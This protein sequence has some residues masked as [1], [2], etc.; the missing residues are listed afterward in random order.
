MHMYQSFHCLMNTVQI[1]VKLNSL[2]FFHQIANANWQQEK[3][4]INDTTTVNKRIS[5]RKQDEYK[6]DNSEYF[7]L[8]RKVYWEKNKEYFSEKGKLYR[9][10][11]KENEQERHKKYQDKHKET[12]KQYSKL[13]RELNKDLLKA[14]KEK[15]RTE[16]KDFIKQVITCECGFTHTRSNKAR[17]IKTIRHQQ[18]LKWLNQQ[19]PTEEP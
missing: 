10:Q 15:Y 17:H 3:D 13:Y 14:K 7:T 19:E 8:Q 9:E 2:S 4:I 1:T 18:Y 16:N 5:D 6:R 12:L 11:N